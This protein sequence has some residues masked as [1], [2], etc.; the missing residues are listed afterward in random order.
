M[1]VGEWFS[2][3]FEVSRGL[4]GKN[5]RPMEGLRGLAVS[6]VFLVHYVAL[7]RPWIEGHPLLDQ[8]ADGMH[9]IGNTGVDLFFVL[10]GY[11]IYGILLKK[12]PHFL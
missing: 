6:L 12:Q 4:Q 1:S 7:I 9:T 5:V 10:S 8:V 2:D 3:K 11:L